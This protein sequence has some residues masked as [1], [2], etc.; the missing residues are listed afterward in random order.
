MLASVTVRVMVFFVS[1]RRTRAV[2]I[3]GMRV[4]PDGAWM[5]QM[6]RNLIDPKDGFLRNATP[7]IH[8]RDPLF[9]SAWVELLKSKGERFHQ[10]LGGKLIA[11]RSISEN[12]NSASDGIRRRSRL[13]ELL[14]F[15][16]R[17]AA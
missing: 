8:D 11:P 16:H 14:N 1:E 17:E 7:L 13:G 4:N 3:A 10:G 15:Y 5:M 2:Y 12:D 9:T 6:V